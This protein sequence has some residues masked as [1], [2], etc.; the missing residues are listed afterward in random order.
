[1]R[2]KYRSQ[3][4]VCQGHRDQQGEPP[5]QRLSDQA[6]W[7]P[8][9]K[10]GEYLKELVDETTGRV[11]VRKLAMMLSK[12]AEMPDDPE[13]IRRTLQRHIADGED[14]RDVSDRYVKAIS[15]VLKIGRAHV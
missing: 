2:P 7:S 5:S 8:V 6:A 12:R 14:G 13:K 3:V 11:S 9:T 10:R 4:T 15:E 1:M